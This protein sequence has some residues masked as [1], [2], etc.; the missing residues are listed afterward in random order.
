MTVLTLYND[1][2]GRTTVG[3]RIL[4]LI[5]A[6][7]FHTIRV[8]V[9]Y[10]MNSGVELLLRKLTRFINGGGRVKVLFGDDFDISESA[11]LRQLHS[12]NAELRLFVGSMNYHPKVW[13]FDG[14]EESVSIVGSSNLSK[15]AL[16]TN[17][18][19]NVLVRDSGFTK[20][21]IDFF[22][23]L[24]DNYGTPIDEDW[25]DHYK[26]REEA[27]KSETK[28]KPDGTLDIKASLRQVRSF[29][30]SWQKYIR[31]P[32]K[33]GQSEYWRGWYFAPEPATFDD[34][35]LVELQRVVAAILTSME[36][37]EKGMVGLSPEYV[38][39]IVQSANITYKGQKP[40]TRTQQGRRDLFIRQHKNYLEKLGFLKVVDRTG[41]VVQ[42][43][44]AGMRLAASKSKDRR[45]RLFAEAAHGVRWA[46]A[47]KLDCV[48]FVIRLLKSL[49]RKRLYF[50]EFSFFVIHA[51]HPKT[52]ESIGRLTMM[53]R[54]LPSSTK[55]NFIRDAEASLAGDLRSR[56]IMAFEHY[57]DKAIEF[58]RSLGNIPGVRFHEAPGDYAESYL[59]LAHVR[60]S[61]E[62]RRL[63]GELE[64]S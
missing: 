12:R 61:E 20:T 26:D 41:P 6:R 3:S 59:E 46:W 44:K 17:I 4:R 63:V 7:R 38:D 33:K 28:Y 11:G 27:A 48:R 43:T 30:K 19:V 9:S 2:Q 62:P 49:P 13:L 54:R 60:K 64:A 5:D 57:Q 22:E 51:D 35:K 29:V 55:A 21:Q 50:H 25:I 34:S 36:Y 39:Q 53:F 42:I 31:R 40:M 37:R 8:A 1:P 18:E 24:W 58:M 15:P 32:R 10:I 23:D 47:P 45:Q 52:F 16:T 14:N 56:G